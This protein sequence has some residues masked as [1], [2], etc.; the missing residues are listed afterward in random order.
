M[1]C[2][3]LTLHETGVRWAQTY[4]ANDARG[5][6]LVTNEEKTLA[7]LGSPSNIGVSSLS[8]LLAL[9]VVGKSLGLDSL[10]AEEKELFA[11]DEVSKRSDVSAMF[12]TV[13]ILKRLEEQGL[14]APRRRK[15]G[16]RLG[17][18]HAVLLT[19]E[20]SG[21]EPCGSSGPPQRA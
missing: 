20:S 16:E 11:G 21:L 7:S 8:G 15:L 4:Q 1:T 6:L 19:W 17:V 9:Q 5:V 12:L 14:F 13:L 3:Q 10:D 2:R 18:A